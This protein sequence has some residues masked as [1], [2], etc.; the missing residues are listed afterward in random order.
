VITL[1]V[2][3]TAPAGM[4]DGKRVPPDGKVPPL[5]QP[6]TWIVPGALGLLIM[7][8]AA[9]RTRRASIARLR[10]SVLPAAS[11]LLLLT[12]LWATCGGGGTFVSSLP[13]G[14]TPSGSYVVT[15]TATS[16]S[17]SHA[18]TVQLTVR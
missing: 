4:L 12:M 17:L 1:R 15:V 3:T 18:V 5:G 11:A 2:A 7:L 13:T 14:G 9:A 10:W 6:R 16:G 8:A